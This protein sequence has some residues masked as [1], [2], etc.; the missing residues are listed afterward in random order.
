M[1]KFLMILALFLIFS[2]L[3]NINVSA[4]SSL[5][6]SKDKLHKGESI[7]LTPDW[8]KNAVIYELNTRQFSKEGT[9]NAI[10]PRVDELKDL[11]V[12]IIWFMPIHPIGEKNRKGSL[13]S[14]YSVKDY[15][16]INPEFGT[17]EDFR[18]LVGQIHDAGMRVIIDLVANHTAWDNPLIEQ[19]P[20]WYTR[21]RSGKIVPPVADWSDVADLNYENRE[22][23]DYMI[24]MMEFWVRDVG[25]DG[26]RCD[27]AEMVP[28]EFWIEVRD[29]LDAIKP[30]FMLAEGESPKLHVSGF[31]MT[32]SFALHHLLND[33]A[34][35]DDSPKQIDKMLRYESKNYPPGSMRMR[36]TSSHDENSWKKS[37]ITRMGKGGAKIGAILCFTLPGNPMIYS[38]QEVGNERSLSFFEKDPIEWR[39]SEFRP[40]YQ[41]LSHL[42][43]NS[44]ALFQGD[45][46]KFASD[47]DD[48]IY[49]FSRSFENETVVVVVN[50]SSKPFEGS[51]HFA[52]IDGEFEDV[53][54]G[55]TV[56]FEGKKM[57]VKFE[58]WE[59]RIYT[60][61]SE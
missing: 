8:A 41:K 36:F 38:G 27:V 60:S 19:H 48:Q 55:E 15:Y 52:G 4:S 40:F 25:I 54:S 53:F 59:Y 2:S 32:Y 20:E 47:N 37:A 24:E 16:G 21:D 56:Q 49:A 46:K 22:V 57:Q 13:G 58:D 23:W 34:R 43:K 61:K 18:R 31:D 29:S 51:I 44:Q 6:Q 7:P 3:G 11:G 10:E 39:K 17:M 50:F 1:R 14:Y 35:G 5:I 9:F 33:I 26:Y 30:V 42:F 12:S 28:M 45:I